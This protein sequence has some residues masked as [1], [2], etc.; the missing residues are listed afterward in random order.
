M[1]RL[2][3]ATTAVLA[4]VALGVMG[5]GQ[6]E[7]NLSLGR[8]FGIGARWLPGALAPLSWHS[9]L[10]LALGPTVAVHYWFNE[11]L[12]GELGGWVSRQEGPWGSQSA[13]TFMGGLLLRLSDNPLADGYLAARAIGMHSQYTAVGIPRAEATLND[14]VVPPWPIPETRSS[15]LAVELAGG[16]EWSWSPQVSTSFEV[17]LAYVQVI[18]TAPPP[19]PDEPPDGEPEP[20]TLP[21]PQTLGT[22]GLGIT[23]R[24][25][26]SFHFPRK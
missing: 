15:G 5:W 13:T 23:F 2:A 1:K 16:L 19:P 11:Q 8:G 20:L 17:G 6:G 7:A 25:G 14:N 9:D 12:G 4:L 3:F 10:A 22:T 24:I 18:T 26:I 21:G